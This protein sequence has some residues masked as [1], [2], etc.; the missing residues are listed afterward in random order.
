MPKEQDD[1]EASALKSFKSRRL[2]AE[3]NQKDQ[4]HDDEDDEEEQMKSEVNAVKV[5]R[6]KVSNGR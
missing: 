6:D 2:I 5:E 1:E 3:R 4:D